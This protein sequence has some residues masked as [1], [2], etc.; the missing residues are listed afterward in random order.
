MRRAAGVVEIED[1]SLTGTQH[2]KDAPVQ[3]VGGQFVFA[4]VGIG[5]HEASSRSRVVGLDDSLHA[6]AQLLA[7]VRPTLVILP[8]RMQDVQTFTRLV[9]PFTRARTRWMFGFQR[10]LVR[11]CECDTDIPHEG[12][13]PHTSHTDAM[14][15]LT[16][17]PEAGP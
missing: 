8:A 13:F 15:D 1:D 7:V 2:P 3:R 16:F 14:I 9:E 17:G 12:R 6:A 5:Q 10:R 4:E 11:T